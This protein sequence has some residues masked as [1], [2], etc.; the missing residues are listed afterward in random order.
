[1]AVPF[2]YANLAVEFSQ[3]HQLLS[4]FYQPS[5]CAVT[6]II[7]LQKLPLSYRGPNKGH[8]HT[9]RKYFRLHIFR[10][11]TFPPPPPLVL[12]PKGAWASSFL[13]FLDHTQQSTTVGRTPLND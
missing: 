5:L 3:L 9:L 7:H 8:A 2:I 4:E 10:G 11:T 12:R 13:K 1:M 6:N